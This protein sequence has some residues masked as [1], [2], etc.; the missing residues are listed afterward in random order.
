MNT[1]KRVVV[2]GIVLLFLVCV[3]LIGFGMGNMRAKIAA[4]NFSKHVDSMDLSNL[5]LTIYYVNP[6]I[7]TLYPLGVDEVIDS[8]GEQAIVVDGDTLEEHIDLLK[9]V[10]NAPLKPVWHKAYMNARI[11]YIFEAEGKGKI[12]D[13][14]MWGEYEDIDIDAGIIFVNGAKVKETD[15]FYEIIIPFLP[16]GVARE[17][18]SY[19]SRAD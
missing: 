17:L 3:L 19:L 7:F 16:D 5:T 4:Y 14:V 10:K 18:E 1:K 13:V 12:L 9:Q 15:I 6:S 2:M 11:Y 8:C